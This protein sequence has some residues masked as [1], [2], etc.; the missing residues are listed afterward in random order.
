MIKYQ[1][2]YCN[3]IYEAGDNCPGCGALRKDAIEINDSKNIKERKK[4]L[5]N[6]EYF[7]MVYRALYVLHLFTC[8]SFFGLWLFIPATIMHIYDIFV[9]RKKLAAKNLNKTDVLGYKR[10]KIYSLIRILDIIACILTIIFW[11]LVVAYLICPFEF[12]II[13]YL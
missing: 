10:P 2:T 11:I 7:D 12:I 8:M 5:A 4:E 9:R 6:K 13:V 3:T 1:C